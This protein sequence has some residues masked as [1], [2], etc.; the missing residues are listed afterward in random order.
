MIRPG[1]PVL[2]VPFV[3]AS[4]AIG[5]AFMAVPGRVGRYY[6]LNLVGSGLGCVLFALA[7]SLLGGEGVVLLSARLAAVAAVVFCAHP[8][9]PIPKRATDRTKKAKW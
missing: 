8:P 5:A 4:M 3:F 9:R 6:A 1:D 7:I 2:A